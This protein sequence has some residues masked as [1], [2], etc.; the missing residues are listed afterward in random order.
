MKP[1]KIIP[2]LILTLVLA[3]CHFDINLKQIDGNGNVTTETRLEN[4][5]F[6]E[7]KVGS[8]LD[9]YL[10]QGAQAKV[11]VEADEN[12]QPIIETYIEN[13]K[14]YIKTSENID[15]SSSKKVHVT[16]NSLRNIHASSGADVI[17][18]TVVE[19]ET[20][21]LKSSSG[22]DLQ[23]EIFANQ[24]NLDCSSGADMRISGRATHC[25]ADAS[26]GADIKAKDLLVVNCKAEA[27]SGADITINVKE[28]LDT[29][30][31]SGGDIKYYGNPSAVSTEESVSGRVRKM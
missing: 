10:T 16:Y 21:G 3:S 19:A 31:S 24:V 26:S 28:R 17:G 5:F 14:L 15:R 23:L 29:D 18:N 30:V 13:G 9:V 12:L 11:T 2:L 4:E 27:S 1:I 7:L 22:A 6:D 8:G 25:N 20:L